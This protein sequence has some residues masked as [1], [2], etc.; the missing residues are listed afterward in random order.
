[1]E[2]S[3][4]SRPHFRGTTPTPPGSITVNRIVVA[5]AAPLGDDRLPD[6]DEAAGRDTDTT[7]ETTAGNGE[8][9]TTITG[10]VKK[11]AA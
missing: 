1:M 4:S 7:N 2:L 9:T 11:S 3:G 5:L 10:T 8:K 6:P